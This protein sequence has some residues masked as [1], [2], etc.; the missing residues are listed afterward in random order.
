MNLDAR[1][2]AHLAECLQALGQGDDLSAVLTRYPDDAATLGPLLAVATALPE[3]AEG[4]RPG[5]QAAS[6][7]EFLTAA[8]ALRQPRPAWWQHRVGARMALAAGLAAVVLLLV[9]SPSALPG[10]LLYP[11]KQLTERAWL[12]ATPPGPGR[13]AVLA[14]LRARRLA[15]TRE[16]LALGR[17]AAVSLE[18]PI[19]EVHAAAWVVAGIPAEF[20]ATTNI[21]GTPE[22]GE[23]ARVWGH[24]ADGHLWVD[25]I[26][27]EPPPGQSWSEPPPPG[28]AGPGGG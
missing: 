19:E 26:Q 12:A 6:R 27:C 7:R 17:S 14:T 2:E 11:A 13:D 18:G 1:L 3:L 22:I 5:A 10:E 21:L 20:M 9:L 25:T 24:T 16:L 28:A 15:E 8:A 23:Q 4:P